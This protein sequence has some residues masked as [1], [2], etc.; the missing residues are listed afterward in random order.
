MSTRRIPLHG[1]LAEEF[2]QR[3][4]DGAWPAGSAVP[5]EAELCREFDVSRGTVRQALATLRTEGVIVGGQGKSP[6]VRQ[7]PTTQSFSTF[8]SFSEWAELIG[9]TP[10][11]R[12]VELARRAP[13]AA[14]AAELFGVPAGPAAGAGT[15]AD[16]GGPLGALP[17]VVDV[18]R[19]RLLDGEP[20]ML[21]RTSFALE[22][23]RLLFDFDT[24][25][26][27]IFA[28][29]QSRGVDLY[30][31]RHY[32]DAVAADAEAA[33]LLGVDAGSP[34]LRDRRITST[35]DGRPVEYS[36]DCY[37]PGVINF[38]IDNTMDQRAPL[39]RVT[40]SS[41]TAPTGASDHPASR[42]G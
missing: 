24:D 4:A 17:Q 32:I 20:V 38:S 2:R 7:A 11:Q 26:G 34:L 40:T 8:H 25:A 29:L 37:L 42:A 6:V 22:E 1:R 15:G 39:S 41:T 10:G 33:E 30:S 23:G 21:E 13:G 28:Y 31:A 18:V 19:V 35:R 16:R 12:T 5:A 3:I 36:E 9:R 14:A 27:S